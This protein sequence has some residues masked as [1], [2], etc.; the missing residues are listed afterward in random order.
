MFNP[1]NRGE[2]RTIITVESATKTADSDG[3]NTETWVNVFGTGITA[4]CKWV[5]IHGTEATENN[6]YGN[7]KK[8]TITM[9]Y[10][11]LITEVCRIKKGTEAWEIESIDN[12]NDRTSWLEIKVKYKAV[13]T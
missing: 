2:L 5:N 8:A 9:P 11:P 10:S 6:R 4:Y 12:V 1:P 13:A 3:Y 7:S